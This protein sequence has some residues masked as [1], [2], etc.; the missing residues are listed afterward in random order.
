[1]TPDPDERSADVRSGSV[2]LTGGTGF[3]GT[4]LRSRLAEADCDVTLLV[5]PET[6][7][8]TRATESVH[9][10]T[11]QNL[12]PDELDADYDA[13]V[14][15]A[16]R[17]SVEDA[18]SDPAH[19]WDVNATGTLRV[20]ELARRLDVDRVLYASTASVYG[21]PQTLPIG[22]DH[23]TNPQE[24]YGA[25]KLAG[26]RLGH[27][28]YRTYGLPVVVAR[29]FNTFGP[30]QPEH[31]VVPTVLRQALAGETVELG[32][33]APSRDFLY[34]KD[35]VD[36]LWCVLERGN[37]GEVYNVAS[38]EDITIGAFAERIVEAAGVEVEIV[39]VEERRRAEG[40]EIPRHVGDT[41]KLR[42]LGWTPSY[43]LEEALE[44]TIN[45]E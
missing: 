28:Y 17:T 21:Q 22:E 41:E 15:L 20:F 4:H 33:L 2:F 14:H 24:P 3:V 9:R 11:V 35:A 7:V 29:V 10:G 43:S 12:D 45:S 37:A 39:S 36:A 32:N 40:I 8:E 26:D 31:N 18:V 30:R 5:R 16:A 23:P 6:T 38:G 27:A 19:T 34:V 42:A 44:E 25:S 13:V 1:M